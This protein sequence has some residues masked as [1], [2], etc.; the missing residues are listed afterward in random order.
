MD[1][2]P[3]NGDNK[4][5]YGLYLGLLIILLYHYYR[6]GQRSSKRQ[7]SGDVCFSV[8]ADI[9]ASPSSNQSQT[10]RLGLFALQE[11]LLLKGPVTEHCRHVWR[12]VGQLLVVK[13]VCL[14]EAVDVQDP[15]RPLEH[16]DRLR[17]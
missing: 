1:P 5:Y 17:G 14:H 7:A 3:G 2:P 9:F 8:L 10:V 16:P 15:A 6:V 11:Q 12:V 13:L 4:G